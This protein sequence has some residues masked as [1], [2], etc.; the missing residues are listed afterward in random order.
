MWLRS[1]MSSLAR[2]LSAAAER[3][4]GGIRFSEND[5]GPDEFD[6]AIDIARRLV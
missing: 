6:P 5:A 3:L 4:F 2:V 1:A